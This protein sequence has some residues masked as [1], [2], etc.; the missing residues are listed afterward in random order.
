MTNKEAAQHIKVFLSG[1]EYDA[2]SKEQIEAMKLAHN[3]LI[4]LDAIESASKVIGSRSYDTPQ[5][6][7]ITFDEFGRPWANGR[8]L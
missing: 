1:D 7:R 8:R 2:P 4:E 6:N 5:P 3:A